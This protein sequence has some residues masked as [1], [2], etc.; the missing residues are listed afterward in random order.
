MCTP[1]GITRRTATEGGLSLIELLVVM[2]VVGVLAVIAGP[3]FINQKS[4][5]SDADAKSTALTAKQAIESCA[6]ET[7]TYQKCTESELL[8][9]EPS[10]KDASDRL[11]VTTAAR[12]YQVVVVSRRD[13]GVT[14]TLSRAS[15][16]VTTRS[17]STGSA[18]RGGCVPP[19]TGTW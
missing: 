8:A 4:K 19:T 7:G 3:S 12:S 11:D 14:F 13:P 1:A 18:D 10:L 17:C 2:I 5:G 16:G 6:S 9:I 15:N